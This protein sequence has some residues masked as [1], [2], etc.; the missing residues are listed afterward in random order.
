MA[1]SFAPSFRH[2]AVVLVAALLP[3]L[4]PRAAHSDTGGPHYA[5]FASTSALAEFNQLASSNGPTGGDAK[6]YG[7]G[8][9]LLH[10]HSRYV[11]LGVGL[12]YDYAYGRQEYDDA[13]HLVAIP[14]TVALTFPLGGGSTLRTGLGI[15]PVFGVSPPTFS[16]GDTY[17]MAGLSGELF[18]GISQRITASGTALDLHVGVRGELL[19]E[20]PPGPESE[21]GEDLLLNLQLLFVRTGITWR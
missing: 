15:G 13:L 19:T 3:S 21:F 4:A 20:L 12:R 9:A 1:P 11:E 6:A 10:A 17:Y 8:G 7:F 14:A 2:P 16:E 18:L 5:A